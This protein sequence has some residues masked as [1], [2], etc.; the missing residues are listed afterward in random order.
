MVCLARGSSG[1]SDLYDADP[2]LKRFA[3]RHTYLGT[4]AIASRDLGVALIRQHSSTGNASVRIENSINAIGT[5]TSK[6]PPSPESSRR[7]DERDHASHKRPRVSPPRD[8][9]RDRDR[10]RDWER[11]RDRDRREP[12]RRRYGSPP[13]WERERE[14]ERDGTSRRPYEKE[15]EEDKPSVTLPPIVSWFV[16]TLP[17]S[18]KFDGRCRRQ[19]SVFPPFLSTH[20]PVTGPVFRTDDLLQVFRNAVIPNVN[21]PRSPTAPPPRGTV[22]DPFWLEIALIMRPY[23]S[24]STA[25]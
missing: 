2:P 9:E 25:A 3:Q 16:G 24:N 18:S 12:T 21:R 10:D 5:A 20:A 17:E 7:R 11:E 19:K 1:C 15:R 23:R 13:Q 4:D 22:S 8:R 6:R 14:R